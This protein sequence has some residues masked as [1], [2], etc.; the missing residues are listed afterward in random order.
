MSMRKKVRL[1]VVDEQNKFCDLV[2]EIAELS[3][4]LYDIT[5]EFTE[6]GERALELVKKWD[7]SVILV[8]AHLHDVNSCDLVKDCRDARAPVV[9]TSEEKSVAIEEAARGWGASGYVTKSESMED[10]ERLVLELADIAT[11]EHH[12]H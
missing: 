8:D 10:V 12:L 2:R 11:A 6:S 7:P 9:V 1:L 5:C 4:H 3:S